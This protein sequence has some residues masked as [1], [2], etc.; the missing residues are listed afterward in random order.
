MGF[1]PRSLG[2]LPL[3]PVLFPSAVF[4]FHYRKGRKGGG[5]W[6]EKERCQNHLLNSS[7]LMHVPTNTLIQPHV[8]R[9]VHTAAHT[10]GCTSS[11]V[12]IHPGAHQGQWSKVP[13]AHCAK[14]E[15]NVSVCVRVGSGGIRPCWVPRWP[16]C[17]GQDPG[18]APLGAGPLPARGGAS[19]MLR[20]FAK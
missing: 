18:N 12:Y 8:R 3:S 7:R 16:F 11:W 9:V 5:G 6:V 2:L 19:G 13:C 14:N 20:A 17:Q 10:H 4:S 1:R 15:E